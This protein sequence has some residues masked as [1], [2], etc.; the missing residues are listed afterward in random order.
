MLRR[1]IEHPFQQKEAEPKWQ[2]KHYL[3]SS[4]E[5][6]LLLTKAEIN[7][8]SHSRNAIK[9]KEKRSSYCF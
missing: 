6:I 7:L 9:K 2:R 3:K 1:A 4:K 5:G 8:V